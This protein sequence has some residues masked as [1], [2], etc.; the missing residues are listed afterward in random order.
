MYIDRGVSLYPNIIRIREDKK[1]LYGTGI[2]ISEDS[3]LTAAHV[4]LDCE[5]IIVLWGQEFE[6]IVKF[7]DD[8]VAIIQVSD[9]RFTNKYNSLTDKLYFTKGEVLDDTTQWCV[10]GYITENLETHIIQGVGLFSAENLSSDY[11]VGTIKAGK[12]NN[13]R[14]LSGSPVIVNDRAIG[15]LQI[16]NYDD[17]AELGIGF[18]SIELIETNLPESVIAEPEYYLKLV[19]KSF[20]Q[21]SRVISKN[22][23][24][25]KYIPEIFV[26]E[27]GY[28][29]L[30][31]YFSE[32]VLFINKVIDELQLLDFS[33]I[34]EQ[35]KKCGSKQIEFCEWKNEITASS[36][37]RTY[38]YLIQKIKIAQSVLEQFDTAKIAEVSLEE[39]YAQR[40]NLNGSMKWE[41]ADTL[42]QLAF[43]EYHAVLLTR[44]AGQGKTNFLC[45]YINN[46]LLK[47]KIPALCYNASEFCENP[48][49]VIRKELTFNGEYDENYVEAILT[50]KWNM[51]KLPLIIVIDGLNEN[52][53]LPN[54]GNYIKQSLKELFQYSFIKIVMS[55]RN[56]LFEERFAM[57]QSKELG[58][59]FSL[60]DMSGHREDR[61]KNRIFEGYLKF[62]NIQIAEGSLSGNT[63]ELLANDTLLLRFFCEVNRG[64]KQVYMYDIYKYDLFD[65]YYENKKAEIKN[66][67]QSGDILFEKMLDTICGFM[68]EN[69]SF[70]NIPR[71]KLALEEQQVLNILLE[72][73]VIFK[74]DQIV[75]RGYLEEL[76]SVFSFTFDE[77]RDFC[78]TRYLLKMP[79]AEKTFPV[80]WKMI[81]DEKWSILEGVERYLFFLSRTSVPGILP[82][83]K[84]NENYKKLYWINVWNLDD[85]DIVKDDIQNWERQFFY[86]G[87]YRSRITKYL[88]FRKNREYFHNASIELLYEWLN[89]LANN[90]GEFENYIKTCFPVKKL[91]RYNQVLW[92]KE[93]V[94]NYDDIVSEIRIKL[95]NGQKI[96][97][98]YD[99][100]KITLYLYEIMPKET[101]NIWIQAQGEYPE[102]VSKIVDDLL[103]CETIPIVLKLNAKEIMESLVTI[104]QNKNIHKLFQLLSMGENYGSVN[105]ILN[106]IWK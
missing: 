91:D 78:L 20:D 67:I 30:L 27:G 54:F 32:P 11:V 42:Q 38:Q 4:V 72:A 5:T 50:K 64:K 14:G 81:C 24:S 39:Y 92:Q 87:A 56:E 7:V 88:L 52:T 33:K 43:M 80:K 104:S 13:Y 48:V 103:A 12:T 9:A 61:F 23:K 89:K 84:A 41:L 35:L 29:D 73:D 86:K 1:K 47:K 22:I 94:R 16:Q 79:D 6:G 34:N 90:P 31:R 75:K 70:N 100:L 60:L 62:F 58:N 77:F 55:T 57:L 83:I 49:S 85:K 36:Y 46:Y 97:N 68:L 93:C 15:I 8:Y 2:I 105:E 37:D 21:C 19:G 99:H 101:R 65:K 66:K 10:E 51:T 17:R 102:I 98:F 45:D 74:E 82:I 44:N 59:Q 95:V 3:V 26:E 96:R 18:S 76:T 53:S 25:A 69:K 71:K 40:V 63:Y 106:A 28:K